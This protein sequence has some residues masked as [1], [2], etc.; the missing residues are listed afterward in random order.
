[1]LKDSNSIQTKYGGYSGQYMISWYG[2]LLDIGAG[3]TIQYKNI[4]KE[5]HLRN[6][7]IQLI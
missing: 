3:Y 7:C 6:S 5:H 2:D 1:M 4:I